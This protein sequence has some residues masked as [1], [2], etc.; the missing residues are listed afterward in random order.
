MEVECIGNTQIIHMEETGIT[1]RKI[2]LLSTFPVVMALLTVR[3]LMLNSCHFGQKHFI[4]FSITKGPS[5]NNL[6]VGFGIFGKTANLLDNNKL[7]LLF[8]LFS[9]RP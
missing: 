8:D 3:N 6:V 7:V 9:N 1:Q 2:G 4:G 5:R